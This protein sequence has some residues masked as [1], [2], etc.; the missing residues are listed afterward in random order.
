[1]NNVAFIQKLVE[2]YKFGKDNPLKMYC[3]DGKCCL[4]FNGCLYEGVT[5]DQCIA[6]IKQSLAIFYLD[7]IERK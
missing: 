5:F 7:E 3:N 1:M 4:L 2:A 6:S